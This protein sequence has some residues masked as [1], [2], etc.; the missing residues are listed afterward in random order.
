MD[1]S[2]LPDLEEALQAAKLMVLMWRAREVP[3][4]W[5][6]A[7]KFVEDTW[8]L[9][10]RFHCAGWHISYADPAPKICK[11]NKAAHYLT[12]L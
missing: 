3:Y 1:L 5:D 9:W 6:T 4:N 7:G 11:T 8:P 12:D 2:D 10:R